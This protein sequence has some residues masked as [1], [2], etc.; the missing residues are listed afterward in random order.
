MVQWYRQGKTPNSSTRALWQS[1]QQSN[2]VARKEDLVEGNDKFGLTKY[3]CSYFEVIFICR[4]ILR[5]GADGFT[6]PLTPGVLRIYIAHENPSTRPVLNPRTLGRKA[7]ALT[8]TAP[9]RQYF[10]YLTFSLSNE[11]RRYVKLA[12]IAHRTENNF[13]T[14]SI[15]TKVLAIVTFPFFCSKP[16]SNWLQ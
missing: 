4:T 5:H 13:N 11:R 8:I 16:I 3:L 7:R 1:C 14:A 9:R 15:H 10:S 2:L 6:S 12:N